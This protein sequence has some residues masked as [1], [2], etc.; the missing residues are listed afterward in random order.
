MRRAGP[1]GMDDDEGLFCL[2]EDRM[3]YESILDIEI[4]EEAIVLFAGIRFKWCLKEKCLV[5]WIGDSLEGNCCWG[6]YN[7]SC[8]MMVE[9]LVMMKNERFRSEFFAPD[10]LRRT[11]MYES[12]S[13]R[14]FCKLCHV[15]FFMFYK[16][17]MSLSFVA[18]NQD[19]CR[20]LFRLKNLY[21][22]Q[23]KSWEKF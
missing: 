12:V 11:R 4:A 23:L 2:Q 10:V 21:A 3:T 8:L 15:W 13:L 14:N 16:L 6:W 17:M 20:G 5:L 19:D 18:S 1:H 7:R 22:N 9:H